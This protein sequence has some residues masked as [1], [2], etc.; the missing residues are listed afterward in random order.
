MMNFD[1]SPENIEQFRKES[2]ERLK[3]LSAINKTASILKQGKSL[4]ETL[5]QICL[6]LPEAYQY[7]EFTTVRIKFNG[8]E[9]VSPNFVSSP[10][11][12]EQ[13]FDTID[14][15]EGIIEIY[16]L[17]D[18]PKFDEGP[19]LNEE[20]DLI[21]NISNLIS[22]YLNRIT[23]KE[24]LK[25][26]VKKDFFLTE[27]KLKDTQITSRRLLQKFLNKSNS[28]R[29]IY[30]DLMPF[31]VKEIL[32]IANLYDAY[33]IEKEGRFSEHVLGE[34]QQ[35]NLT[36][37]PRITGVS[38]AEEAFEQLHSKHFDLIIMM[39]GVDRK[40]PTLISKIIKNEFQYIP[41]F[42]LLNSSGDIDFYETVSKTETS[43]DRTFV[44][45]G[46][47]RIFFAMIKLV[48]DAINIENDTKIGMVRVILL[49][50]DSPNYYS[51]YL[52]LLYKIVMEQTKRLIDDVSTD[53]LYK[54]L[55]LRAR[56]KIILSSS[57][58]GAIKT[59][60]RYKEY[61]L[62]LIT[63]VKYEK[64]GEVDSKAGFELVKYTRK[65]IKEIPIIIQSSEDSNAEIAYKLNTTFIN[66]N[67]E[68]LI[69]DFE[70]FIVHYLGFGNFIY[71][72]DSGR[73]IGMAKTLK[74]FENQLKIIPDE[75]LLYHARK[76]HFSLWLMARGE[77]Q[78]AKILNP[79][80]VSDFKSSQKI[81]EVLIDVIQK[82][83][84]EQN[85]GKIIPFEESAIL[86]ETNIVNLSDGSL[87]GKGRG[88]AFI[89]SLI[90]NYDFSKH[91]TNINIR[92][93]KTSVIGTDEF[94]LFLDNNKLHSKIHNIKDYNLIKKIFLEAKLTD[95]L[96]KR[97][98]TILRKN[99][100]ASGNQIIRSFRG[101]YKSTF[102][103]YF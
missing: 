81:R 12:Q 44:W 38:S 91:V 63:D 55:R 96:S 77:I 15:K 72:D 14:N 99:Q 76:N 93:P 80:K 84:N 86:D 57:F 42:L 53:E 46:D 52:P 40:T 60:D 92:T 73:Q 24:V 36:S 64:A 88:L 68:S 101:L 95:T 10:W 5:Q 33:S 51:R 4:D 28:D 26:S 97:I 90:Y 2:L 75:S 16:Y 74:E 34:Y 82:F 9:Y 1:K 17:Q 71:R 50:E 6:I 43:I 65:N 30:H 102:R 31:K 8:N 29:D 19:F 62:C 83:R 20:R 89:N 37:V 94:D 39:A 103:R 23:G 48:E 22:G 66:K 78:A 79:H 35:L 41:I 58:E 45:N 85:K 98:K 70:S 59:L 49:V 3:E 87:G 11:K 21:N 32:L 27:P 54:V 61:M 7:P 18:F 47:S 67:S 56:P 25:K 100:K 13:S 69:Q